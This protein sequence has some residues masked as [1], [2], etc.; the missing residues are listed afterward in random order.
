MTKQAELY[1]AGIDAFHMDRDQ[2]AAEHLRV[3]GPQAADSSPI[4]PRRPSLNQERA[5]TSDA[6][7]TAAAIALADEDGDWQA[8][9]RIISAYWLRQGSAAA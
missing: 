6:A 7:I 3:F 1:A 8:R 9:E 2:V 5:D 4:P